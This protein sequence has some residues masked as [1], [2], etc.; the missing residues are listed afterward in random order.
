MLFRS[1]YPGEQEAYATAGSQY[2]YGPDLLVAPVTTPGATASTSVWFPP[3]NTWT[4]YFTGR[5]YAGGT[6]ASITT[7]LDTMPVFVRS[8]AA[9]P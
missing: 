7:T 8:G 1:A 6:T 9:K 5:T 3:G 4:D 2:L